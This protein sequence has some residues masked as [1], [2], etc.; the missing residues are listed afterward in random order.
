MPSFPLDIDFWGQSLHH[1]FSITLQLEFNLIY[2]HIPMFNK[3]K[4]FCYTFCL[5]I[6]LL[7]MA[8]SERENKEL[9]IQI[10][11][12]M[13]FWLTIKVF[14]VFVLYLWYHQIF[15]F[16]YWKE[17]KFVMCVY[18]AQHL[19][20]MSGIRH[21]GPHIETGSFLFLT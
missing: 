18:L 1:F 2:T 16:F 10:Y 8:Y 14:P 20:E 15:L 5:G 4:D 3:T 7:I 11:L 13:K 12:G 19:V 17:E 9:P 6:S 21:K